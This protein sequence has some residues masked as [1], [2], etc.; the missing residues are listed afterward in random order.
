VRSELPEATRYL[1]SVVDDPFAARSQYLVQSCFALALIHTA[2]GR[3]EDA[4]KVVES[5]MSHVMEN[6]DSFAFAVGG[7]DDSYLGKNYII[8]DISKIRLY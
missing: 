1:A 4:S 7:K 3:D 2:Q 5:V 6:R 8:L